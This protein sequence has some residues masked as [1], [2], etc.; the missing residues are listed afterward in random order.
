MKPEKSIRYIFLYLQV[1]RYCC[2][3]FGKFIL[4][5]PKK[6]IF[7]PTKIDCLH[8][9]DSIAFLLYRTNLSF[10]FIFANF[11]TSFEGKQHMYSF[12]FLHDIGLEDRYF[13]GCAVKNFPLFR[14][15]KIINW[16]IYLPVLERFSSQVSSLAHYFH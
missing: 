7:L 8:L 11:I 5:F 12:I 16:F 3:F 13:S 6:Y 9:H 2:I 15:L 4:Q 14:T 10:S 1:F